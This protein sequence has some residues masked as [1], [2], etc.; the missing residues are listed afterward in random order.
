MYSKIA[1]VSVRAK[2]SF[3]PHGATR[4]VGTNKYWHRMLHATVVHVVEEI[5]NLAAVQKAVKPLRRCTCF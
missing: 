3:A 5:Q 2:K 1:K 4:S